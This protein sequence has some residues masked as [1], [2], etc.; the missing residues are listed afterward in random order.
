MDSE[1]MTG[2]R[3]GIVGGGFAGRQAACALAACGADVTVYD[4]RPEAVMLP[5]LP[6]LAGGWVPPRL[7]TA[8]MEQWLPPGVRLE[9]AT[10]EVVDVDACAVEAGG[11]Q[12]SFDVLVVA[13][14][15]RAAP[16]P[17]ASGTPGVHAVD[18]LET[19][20][21][22]RDA[23]EVLLRSG[24]APRVVVAGGGY[25]GLETAAA[26]A[27]R[28]RA[29]GCGCAM[30][31]VESGPVVLPFLPPARREAALRVLG[32]LGVAC[33]LSERVEGF[34]GRE[35]RLGGERLESDLLVWTVGSV[36]SVPAVR[37]AVEQLRDGR[38]VTGPDLSLPGAPRVFA[39]GDAAAVQKGGAVL[40][41]AVNFAWYGGRAAGRNASRRL[42]GLPTRRFREPC[43]MELIV[44]S[45]SLLRSNCCSR[46]TLG[47]RSGSFSSQSAC[48]PGSLAPRWVSR[49]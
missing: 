2:G 23:F 14:G 48:A 18:S 44:S 43:S 31:V 6:D 27:A 40:R 46:G 17:F 34:D 19:A 25:T 29:A 12:E 24:R 20:R 21:G 4:P 30:T 26:L 22:L 16:A 39:A 45:Q 9:R 15:S 38:L 35:V 11:R 49:R 28:A 10:V 1:A 5:A 13:C 42:R 36:L 33:R 3:A 8:P 47:S 7:L 41:K 32:G 37:G